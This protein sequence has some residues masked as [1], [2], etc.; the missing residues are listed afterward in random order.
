MVQLRNI[1]FIASPKRFIWECLLLRLLVL[2]VKGT[3][4]GKTTGYRGDLAL[5]H[6]LR[7]SRRCLRAMVTSAALASAN[8]LICHL[9]GARPQYTH[10]YSVQASTEMGKKSNSR[11]GRRE[12]NKRCEQVTGQEKDVLVRLEAKNVG[13]IPQ[14]L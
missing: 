2:G 5:R 7:R 1:S 10:Q 3:S 14:I 11:R 9:P 4:K 8:R 13:L 6:A 12:K